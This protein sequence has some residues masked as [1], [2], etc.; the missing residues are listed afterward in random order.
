MI[1]LHGHHGFGCNSDD[2]KLFTEL[3][4][5]LLRLPQPRIR[6]EVEN[7]RGGR[8]GLWIQ[9]LGRCFP[10]LYGRGALAVMSESEKGTSKF[11]Y[12]I[13]SKDNLI[14][15]LCYNS[16]FL[17]G[18]ERGIKALV[19][20]PDGRWMATGSLDAT[21][22]L[23]DANHGYIAQ[24]WITPSYT[25]VNSLAFSPD[26]GQL[27][28]S[29]DG[30]RSNVIVWD[31]CG[32]VCAVLEGHTA[33]VPSCAWS[34]GGDVIASGSFDRTVRLWDAHSF[35]QLHIIETPHRAEL[36][37]FSPNGRWLVSMYNQ[38]HDL[39][40]WDVASGTPHKN[41]WLKP[42]SARVGPPFS[43]TASFDPGSTQLATVSY[44][45]PAIIWEIESG[46][47]LFV[48]EDVGKT[49][50][51]A[52]SPGGQAVVT[53]SR[54]GSVKIW[55]TC[56]GVQ[57]CSV[58]GHKD[59]VTRICFSPCGTYIASASYDGTVQVRRTRDG[60]LV[61]TISDHLTQVHH[62]TFSADGKTLWSGAS[63]G[64]VVSHHMCDIISTDS[65]QES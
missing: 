2:P 7:L 10:V 12:T 33:S 54:D 40:V 37:Q 43:T 60:S 63:D 18:H 39:R 21:I 29:C 34:P 42:D 9:E 13:T 48:L 24:Q 45:S 3:E 38:A 16:A 17:N 23:W 1:Q 49:E 32:N 27:A 41:K 47:K 58:Q 50:D 51:V 35:H 28:S 5:A 46:R 15:C 30:P 6:W 64:T 52:I 44:H 14:L 26:S 53:A 8:R 56:E 55:N 65:D 22:I 31:L 36:V 19:A 61:A 57:L 25:T 59:V 11:R 20:S 62:I 4:Q